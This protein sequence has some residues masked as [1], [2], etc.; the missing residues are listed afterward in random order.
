MKR[1]KRKKGNG[2]EMKKTGYEQKGEQGK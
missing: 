1:E 2:T